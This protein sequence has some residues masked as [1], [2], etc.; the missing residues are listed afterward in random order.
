MLGFCGVSGIRACAEVAAPESNSPALTVFGTIYMIRN[1]GFDAAKIRNNRLRTDKT[2][3]DKK[4][5]KRVNISEY[6][7]C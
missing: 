2:N 4:C 6:G 7:S 5:E 1:V 3:Y